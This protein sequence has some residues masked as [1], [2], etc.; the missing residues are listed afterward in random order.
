MSA[1]AIFFAQRVILGKT[2]FNDVPSVFV[3]AVKKILIENK[4]EYLIPEGEVK[5]DGV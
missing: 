1:I 3:E 4:L 5:T 2:A